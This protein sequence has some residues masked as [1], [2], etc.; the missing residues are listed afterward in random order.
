MP[1]KYL[2]LNTVKSSS[3]K[4]SEN[5]R[6]KDSPCVS[7]EQ[8]HLLSAQLFPHKLNHKE[9]KFFTVILIFKIPSFFLETM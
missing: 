4:A 6:I 8:D 9:T 2:L 5:E 1:I 3:L 7:A